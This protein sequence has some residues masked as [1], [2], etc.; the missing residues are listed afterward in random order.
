VSAF[1]VAQAVSF[2]GMLEPLLKI[3]TTSRKI[4]EKLAQDARF[5]SSLLE[6]P[7]MQHHDALVRVNA[8]KILDCLFEANP[9]LLTHPQLRT[10]EVISLVYQ[11]E[12]TSDI[13]KAI[14]SKLLNSL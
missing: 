1:V 3:I 4:N 11:R 10:K 9:S 5:L 6:K 2:V 13:V 12:T 8:L 7:K 14:A